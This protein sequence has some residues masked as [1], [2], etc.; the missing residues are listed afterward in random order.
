MIKVENLTFSY[1]DTSR[2][3][4][5]NIDLEIGDGEFVLVTGP[6][7]GGKSSLCRCLNGLI[8][9]FYGG[10][11]SGSVT[12]QGLDVLKHPTR[13]LATRVGMVFQDPENQLVATDV[14][15]EIAGLETDLIQTPF[16]YSIV[17]GVRKIGRMGY[18][19]KEAFKTGMETRFCG[20]F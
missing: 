19:P 18:E 16:D 3:A 2:P 17:F 15:R 13:E 1:H 8:P 5:R 14:E 20:S 9:H 4:L 10:T 7:G 6:S 12:V 11:I